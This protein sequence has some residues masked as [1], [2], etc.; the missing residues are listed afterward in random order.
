MIESVHRADQLSRVN[1]AGTGSMRRSEHW[2]D[3][4]LKRGEVSAGRDGHARS[5]DLHILR[6][7]QLYNISRGEMS[8]VGP[9]PLMVDEDQHIEGW[10]RRRL[11]FKPGMT[12]PWPHV[13]ARR[14]L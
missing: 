7:A 9:R 12:G 3:K 2:H 1:A 8:I 10:H 6:C 4:P 5:V 14:G 11:E 13:L